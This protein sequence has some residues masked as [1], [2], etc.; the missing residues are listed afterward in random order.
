MRAVLI[1][2]TAINPM[3]MLDESD[4]QW[5][6]QEGWNH[7]SNL[8]EF[9]GRQCYESWGRPNEQTATL[10]GYIEHIFDVGHH[11][12]LEHATATF[13]FSDV[14]RSFTHEL[15][16]HRHFSY[17]QLSQRFKVVGDG[18]KPIVPEL[19]RGDVSAEETIADMW[20]ND[21]EGYERL[22]E[23]GETIVASDPRYNRMS[24]T[25][26]KKRVREAARCVLPNMTP[27]AIV[28]SGNHRAW[29]H[30]LLTRG[31]V[32]ADLEIRE[33]AFLV[34]E[35]LMQ[36]EE[37]IYDNLVRQGSGVFEEIVPRQK[38]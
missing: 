35:E 16:R 4:G 20:D 14:S 23:I 37:P 38:P 3:A 2:S 32:H 28:V 1:A 19:F 17:S 12:V 15:I 31:S 22:I 24:G 8:S 29:I 18:T 25:M 13:R 26:R 6:P 33:A 10:H 30:F 34:F 7:G 9:A 27:T 5:E 21:R 11:S 36:L